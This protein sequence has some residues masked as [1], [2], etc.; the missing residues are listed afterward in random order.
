MRFQRSYARVA[1]A[2]ALCCALGARAQSP[3]L[4]EVYTRIKDSELQVRIRF[5]VPV[6]YLRHFPA[7]RGDLLKIFFRVVTIDGADLSLPEEARRVKAMSSVPGF[8]VTYIHPP[9]PDIRHETLSV[10]VQ[11]DRPVSYRVGEG[12]DKR[13]L[14]LYIP[15][16]LAEPPDR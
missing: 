9:S 11:F 13:S 4:D 5:V 8:T 6:R 15:A 2:M 16:K 14:Y 3:L 1:A 12:K 7:E 10:L